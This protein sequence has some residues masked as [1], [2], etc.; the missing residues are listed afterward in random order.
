M[1]DHYTWNRVFQEYDEEYLEKHYR[2]V[3]QDGRRYKHENPTGA[4]ISRGVTGQPWRGIDPTAKGR[5][6]LE[7]QLSWRS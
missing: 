1:S 4:G 2:H 7:R 5:H 6:W 3:D